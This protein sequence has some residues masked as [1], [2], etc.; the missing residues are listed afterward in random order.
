MMTEDRPRYR[1]DEVWLD[2]E[3]GDVYADAHG[4]TGP[5]TCTHCRLLIRGHEGFV[6]IAGELYHRECAEWTP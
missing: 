1:L 4:D 2:P 6:W 3:T 5:A